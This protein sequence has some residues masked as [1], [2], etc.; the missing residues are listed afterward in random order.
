MAEL[1]F[2]EN[3]TIPGMAHMAQRFLEVI[4]QR[5][6]EAQIGLDFQPKQNR[7]SKEFFLEAIIKFRG[8]LMGGYPIRLHVHSSPRGQLLNVGY[9]IA[10]DDGG[11][12]ANLTWGNSEEDLMRRRVNLRPENQRELAIIID[13]FNQ[14]VYVPTV[15]DLMDA[16]EAQ[17]RPL[18]GGGFLGNS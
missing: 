16:A 1:D 7:R 9:V 13:S 4:V 15:R 17:R 5:A 11:P 10:S 12:L 8:R 2:Q 18:G 14:A 3:N 6:Q